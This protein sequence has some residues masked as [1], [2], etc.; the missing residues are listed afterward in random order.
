MR[1]IVGKV[2]KQKTLRF[3]NIKLVDAKVLKK[4]PIANSNKKSNKQQKL[5]K[6][7][8]SQAADPKY[9]KF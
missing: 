4:Q 5:E 6:E 9:T 8:P 1:S 3:F 2:E 7:E